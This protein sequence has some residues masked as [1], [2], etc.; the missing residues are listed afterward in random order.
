MQQIYK[1][2][3]ERCRGCNRKLPRISKYFFTADTPSG[4]GATCKRCL[5]EHIKKLKETK[6]RCRKCKRLLQ[7]TMKNFG[8]NRG[9]LLGTCRQ[10]MHPSFLMAV[11]KYKLKYPKRVW[12]SKLISAAKWR[13]DKFKVFINPEDI[14]DL[15][16][17]F[18]KSKNKKCPIC[19]NLMTMNGRG[20]RVASLDKIIPSQGY[21]KGNIAIICYRCNILKKDGIIEEFE[22]IVRF[23]KC[24]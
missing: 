20:I 14:R 12:V 10:C 6:R 21:V 2:R 5:R 11:K 18:L 16:L 19:N 8:T 4:F 3:I 7:A 23:L 1:V 13:A 22:N 9:Y 17:V 24:Y 15:A